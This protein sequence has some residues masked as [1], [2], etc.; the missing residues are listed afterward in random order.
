[1]TQVLF[2]KPVADSIKTRI[3]TE[4]KQLGYQ[5]T[6]AIVGLENDLQW[7]QY[8]K[9][10]AKSAVEY[11][12]TVT[13]FQLSHDATID[14]AI[15]L[16]NKLNNDKAINGILVQQPLPIQLATLP[17]YIAPH[18]DCDGLTASNVFFNYTNKQGIV[19][20][21][22]SAVLEMLKF[23]DISV[24]GKNVVIIGRG[25]AVGKPLSL[26]L[27]NANA[28]VTLCHTKTQQLAN[29]AKKADILVSCCGVPKLINQQFVNTKSVVIDVGLSFNNGNMSGDVD[30]TAIENNCLAYSPV[31]KGIGPV[32]RACLFNNLI[33]CCNLGIE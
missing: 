6:L 22:A 26:L 31:P 3:A 20:A 2:G 24:D 1:M 27:T 21:T 32:T 5:P 18:K 14:N 13:N 10:I 11:N 9:A 28:T 33:R 8:S 16:I 19:P 30:A 17:Q 7:Q 15:E 25:M 23:Y 12:T 4:V 29:I